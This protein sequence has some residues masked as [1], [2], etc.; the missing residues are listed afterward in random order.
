VPAVVREGAQTRWFLIFSC[1]L[2]FHVQSFHC[3]RS[4]EMFSIPA[5]GARRYRIGGTKVYQGPMVRRAQ[6]D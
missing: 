3:L 4:A 5:F 6:V 2:A 1:F